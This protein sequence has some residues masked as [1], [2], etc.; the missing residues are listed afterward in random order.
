[1]NNNNAVVDELFFLL[2]LIVFLFR[3]IKKFLN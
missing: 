3:I 1:M 2:N